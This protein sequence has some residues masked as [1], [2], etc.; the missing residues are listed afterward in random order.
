MV[1]ETVVSLAV[2]LRADD[3]AVQWWSQAVVL[4][5]VEVP[6]LVVSF[7]VDAAD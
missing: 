5:D 7:V 1:G 4:A 2:E 3:S 6:V